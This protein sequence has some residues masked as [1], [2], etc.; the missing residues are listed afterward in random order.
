MAIQ[1]SCL[2][3]AV[4]FKLETPTRFFSHC[5]CET[6]RR[7]HGAAFVSWTGVPDERFEWLSGE[8][9]VTGFQSSH[10]ATRS[11]CSRCGTHLLYASIDWP[12]KKYVPVATLTDPMDREPEDHIH[13]GDAV[14]WCELGD[15]L[16]RHE[17][18]GPE[19]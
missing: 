17:G 9:L 7:A 8:D 5:H 3:G 16:P 2:C 12:G 6:C 1:G 14:G 19:E 4:S 13:I 11:F 15:D 18:F 10:H